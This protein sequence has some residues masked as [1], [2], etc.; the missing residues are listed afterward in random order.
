M[1]KKAK[2]KIGDAV[3]IKNDYG[4][5]FKETKIV[6]NVVFDA[7]RGFIYAIEPTQTPWFLTS[8]RNLRLQ[9]Q[10]VSHARV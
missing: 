3:Y 5:V 4:V 10:G 8:E 1:D 9:K 7:V 6:K 2:F